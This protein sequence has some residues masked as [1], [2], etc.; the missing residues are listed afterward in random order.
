MRRHRRASRRQVYL[1][2]N[3]FVQ[4]ALAQ[5]APLHAAHM[6][7]PHAPPRVW[8]DFVMLLCVLY[9]V[10]VAPLEF[11]FEFRKDYRHERGFEDANV[12]LDLLLDVYFI[13]DLLLNFCTGYVDEES[14]RLVMD[15][16]LVAKVW[17]GP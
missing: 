17:T 3:L 1:D 9:I 15:P 12:V 6:V 8:W 13:C 7:D 14:N 10:V 2:D 4:L 5:N 16:K 11:G